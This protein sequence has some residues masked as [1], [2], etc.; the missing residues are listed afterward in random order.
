MKKTILLFT[1][2]FYSSSILAL[3]P[4]VE[5][6]NDVIGCWE[7]VDFSKAAQKKINEIEPWPIR[8]QWYCFEPDGY[9]YTYGSTKYTTQTSESLRDLFKALTKDIKYTI[10]HKGII[11]TDQNI[12]N[13]TSKQ[14]LAWGANSM[15]DTVLFNGKTLSKGTLIMSLYSKEKQKNIYYRYL[16]RVK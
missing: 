4:P 9:L 11:R 13:S 7:R 1:C 12:P 8:Y 3:N 10:P 16:V 6:I 15:G 14:S 2:V 5:D